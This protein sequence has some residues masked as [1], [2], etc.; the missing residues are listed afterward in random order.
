MLDELINHN[1]DLRQILNEGYEVEFFDI[2]LA[3]NHV[4]YVNEQKQITYGTLVSKSNVFG[5]TVSPMDHTVLWIGSHPCDSEGSQLIK[6]G[7]GV[8]Q[9]QIRE[10]L[11]SNYMF[12]QKPQE[13]YQNYHHKMTQYIKMVENEARAIDSEVTS[14]TFR[15]IKF[16]E[17]ESVFCYIDTAS[18]R[19]GIVSINEKLKGQRIAIVGLGGTGSYILDLLAKTPVEEI[20]LFDGD[21]FHNHNA[22]RS[23]GAPSYDDLLKNMSKV[24]WFTEIYSRM[25]RKIIPHPQLV[26]ES[27]VADLNSMN[28]VFIC[29]DRGTSRKTIINYLIKNQISFI[30]VGMALS[31]QNDM[32]SG[33]IRVT[34]CTPSFHNHVNDRIPFVSDEDDVY[35]SNIQVSD[36]NALNATLAVI[37]WKKMCGFY[38]NTNNEHNTVYGISGNILTND[39][40]QNEV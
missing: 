1:P 16:N 13:G 8:Q 34:T 36:M 40:V 23:P 18:S 29:V 26:D 5:D 31:N 2:Y 28:V 10:G 38:N 17:Y 19:A 21:K 9:E 33:L 22:F 15:P 6:L 20:H 3:I 30:D 37:K 25:R 32:L 4:P 14:K 11:I 27:N 7:G 12:S 39:E 24:E 35:S